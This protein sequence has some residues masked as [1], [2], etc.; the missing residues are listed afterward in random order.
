MAGDWDADDPAAVLTPFAARMDKLVPAWMQRLRHFYVRHQPPRRAQHE[1]GCPRQHPSSLRPVQRPVRAVPRRDDDLLVRA[2]RRPRAHATRRSPTRSGARSTRC[3]TPPASGSAPACSRSAPAGARS[4]CAPRSGVRPSP[5]SRCRRSRPR[6]PVSAPRRAGVS[7]RVDVQLRDYRDVEGQYDA[8]VSVEMIEAVGDEYWPHVLRDPR[9][10]ARAG[11][12]DRCAGDPARARPHAGDARPVHVDQQVHLP[13]RC[14]AVPAGHRGDRRATTPPVASRASTLRRRLR[15]HAAGVARALRRARARGR[16]ARVRRDVP[17]HVGLLPRVLRGRLRLRL[18]RRRP[19]RPHEGPAAHEPSRRA[20]AR[21]HRPE[22]RRR[23]APG[24]A[25]R[26]GREPGRARRTRPVVVLRNRRA[27]R[28]LLWRP[29]ELGL[30]RAYV[31]GDLDVEGDLAD[32]LRRVW[33]FAR[34]RGSR[35]A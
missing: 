15:A 2:V 27:L 9:P 31:T 14:A 29:D 4:R 25:P 10:C 20:D 22:V 34:E 12:A 8:I 11:W 18:P 23:R 3:S 21:R 33:A 1:G 7:G 16:R 5:R 6:G 35:A 24:W 28:R 32:G 17:P 19:D 30:A 26:L 13:R